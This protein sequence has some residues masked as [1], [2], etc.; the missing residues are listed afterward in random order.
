MEQ[1][2][3][4]DAL[5]AEI[6]RRI[7]LYSIAEEDDST[8]ARMGELSSLIDFINSLSEEP[9]SEDKSEKELV[10]A[11]LAVFDKKYPILPTLKGKQKADFKN[12]LNKCQQEFGLKEF[13]IHPTQAKLF[14]KIALLWATWGAKH[15]EGLGKSNQDEF[16]KMSASD[17][18]E[19][20]IEIYSNN[21]HFPI[22]YDDYKRF[23]RHF[24]EWQK[25]K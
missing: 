10:E 19:E 8:F 6:E 17:D 23:A 2:I 15:L 16:D 21:I 13:G 22:C 12:F 14:E 11:Y 9:A 20:E 1:Y 4:K 24:A 25:N 18:L 3:D 7:D 5:V